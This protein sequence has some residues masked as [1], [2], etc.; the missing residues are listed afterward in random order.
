MF[1]IRLEL[2]W[3]DLWIGVYWSGPYG[4]KDSESMIYNHIWICLIPCIPIHIMVK[5]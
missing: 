4:D 2:K 5:Y 3:Q 1:K